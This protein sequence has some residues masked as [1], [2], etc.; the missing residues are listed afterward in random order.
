[1]IVFR[2]VGGS[3]ALDSAYSSC[4]AVS[5]LDPIAVA[6]FNNDSALDVAALSCRLDGVFVLL[7]SRCG[8][9]SSTLSN[10]EVLRG[11][12]L[13]G[14]LEELEL[15]DDSRVRLAPGFTLN[16]K[17]PPIWLALDATVSDPAAESFRFLLESQGNTP[18]L[19]ASVEVW[20]RNTNSFELV[21]EEDATFG[22]EQF[23]S[24]D[25][26]DRVSDFVQPD[27]GEVRSRVGW[28]QTGFV[29]LFP[30]EISIDQ[31]V[32]IQN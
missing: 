9:A 26:S 14:G 23:F 10:F 15:S 5:A 29:L 18:S 1:M 27:T 8:Y 30:W 13:D 21:A 32:L 7:N 16:S 31:I 12:L 4:S 28:S 22:F 24:I 11:N 19:S 25:L 3:F 6:D 20:N 2:N 17:E